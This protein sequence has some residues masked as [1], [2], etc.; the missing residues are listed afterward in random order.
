VQK[1]STAVVEA[2]CRWFDEGKIYRATRLVHWCCTL[3]TAISDC[4]VEHVQYPGR[5]LIKVPG[6]GDELVEVGV[7]TSFAYKVHHHRH[8]R[9]H[10]RHLL[11]LRNPNY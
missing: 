9:Y 4:E 10:A 7:L 1:L 8:R 11:S 5:K 6:Y 2:F 3:N